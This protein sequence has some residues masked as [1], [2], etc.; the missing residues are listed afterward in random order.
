MSRIQVQTSGQKTRYGDS[1]RKVCDAIGIPIPE[2]SDLAYSWIIECIETGYELDGD[3]DPDFFNE[4]LQQESDRLVPIIDFERAMVWVELQQYKEDN[5]G[6]DYV[7]AFSQ[8][9]YDIAFEILLETQS[10]VLA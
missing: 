8:R 10:G 9:L 4:E 2:K 1:V 7:Q 6:E 5:T 3:E